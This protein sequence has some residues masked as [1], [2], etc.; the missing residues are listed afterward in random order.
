MQINKL[1]K[2]RNMLGLGKHEEAIL[3]EIKSN[4]YKRRLSKVFNNELAT[5]PSKAALLQNL[6]EELHFNPENA[7]KLHEGTF[8][9]FLPAIILSIAYVTC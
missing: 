3:L 5:A 4:V 6:C 8:C 1:N 2:L 7:S 9:H